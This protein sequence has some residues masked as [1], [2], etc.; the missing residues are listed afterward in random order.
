M[1]EFQPWPKIPRWSKD[2]VIT[3]KID[4]TNA[5]IFI[6][7][8]PSDV[9]EGVPFLVGSRTRWI[10]PQDDNYGFANWCYANKEEL[11]K[12]GPGYHFGEWWGARIQRKYG[13]KEKHFSLFNVGRWTAETVPSCVSVVPTLYKGPIELADGTSQIENVMESLWLSGSIAAAQIEDVSFDKPEGIVI[14]H[15]GGGNYLFKKTFEKDQ[16]GKG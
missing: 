6:P 5:S 13:L 8:I 1:M 12:L 15:T 10:T 14:F 16:E 7:E 9:P 4:G 3:E 11:L 2:I